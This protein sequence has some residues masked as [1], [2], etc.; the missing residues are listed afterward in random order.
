MLGG[1]FGVGTGGDAAGNT[2][3]VVSNT[4]IALNLIRDM[5]GE[6]VDINWDTQGCKI[7]YNE[8]LNCGTVDQEED[9]DIGGGGCR[10]IEVI[11]NTLDSGG[12]CERNIWVKLATERVTIKGNTLRGA[13]VN[14]IVAGTGG[15]AIEDL[16]ITDGNKIDGGGTAT[17]R[18]I[19]LNDCAVF[20]V[21]RNKVWGFADDAITALSTC[22][23]GEIQSNDCSECQ[24]GIVCLAPRTII[25]LNKCRSN[26]GNGI[27]LQ[28]DHL[29]CGLNESHS[30]GGY[31]LV[32]TA[33][34]DYAL[35]N[36]NRLYD[37]LGA[38]GTQE[39]VTFTGASDRVVFTNNIC[40]PVDTTSYD[41]ISALTNS[42]ISGNIPTAGEFATV[43]DDAIVTVT[44]PN[45]SG[46]I[47]VWVET[48][49]TLF[50]RRL[51]RVGA[52][53]AM[54]A[55]YSG[56]A[57]SSTTGSLTGT[58]GVDGQLTISAKTNGTIDI[59]NRSGGSQV[60]NW[61]FDSRIS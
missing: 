25:A 21:S 19:E 37:P 48:A 12:N 26:T 15:S 29:T 11:G 13:T 55:A 5:R 53:P 30:N 41:G 47:D 42:V 34:S 1:D 32:V 31:G 56:A 36:A 38:S 57:F 33:G 16:W 40:A 27:N 23:D 61:R 58:T 35:I 50:G 24:D 22:G 3:G 28:A 52:S 17:G 45:N 18:G 59:E 54:S 7:L 44:P 49:S 9:I 10:D 8:I 60:I 43:A 20:K 6:G 39:G 51:F 14:G 4:L 2:N 46:F